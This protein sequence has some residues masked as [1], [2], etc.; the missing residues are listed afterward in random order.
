MRRVGGASPRVRIFLRQS[1]L[2]RPTTARLN[3]AYYSTK[4]RF[5]KK[6]KM[7]PCLL[8]FDTHSHAHDDLAHLDAIPELDV[9][10]VALMGTTQNDWY[11]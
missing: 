7:E 2:S 10:K 6:K 1:C 5:V 9:D 11:I 3:C 8:L 4:S